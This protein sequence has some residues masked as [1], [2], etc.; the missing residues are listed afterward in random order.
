M[1]WCQKCLLK[2]QMN[3]QLNKML[4]NGKSYD[5]DQFVLRPIILELGVLA[6]A[7]GSALFNNGD[8]SLAASIYG[9]VEI[10]GSG[11][12]EEQINKAL[13]EVYYQRVPQ[14]L[15][16]G[17]DDRTVEKFLCGICENALITNLH[18]LTRFTICVQEI[19]DRGGSLAC[20]VN[21]VCAALLDACAPL[22]WTFASVSCVTLD[23]GTLIIDPSSDVQSTSVHTLVFDS[24]YRGVVASRSTGRITDEVY[25]RC[26]S[27]CRQA[28][29]TVF[30]AYRDTY[31]KRLSTVA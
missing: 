6:H 27:A 1:L 4:T 20:A 25:K 13:L 23:D 7:D 19:Q 22:R 24:R 10:R 12:T 18:P 9:P 26:V 29:E 11:R 21:A 15:Q 17:C 14:T 2:L 28:S 31:V 8:T 5:G 30:A 16:S 3:A